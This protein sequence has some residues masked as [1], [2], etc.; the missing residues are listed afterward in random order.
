MK[1]LVFYFI[2]LSAILQSNRLIA[3]SCI[4]YSRSIH[5]RQNMSLINTTGNQ[6]LDNYCRGE[7]SQVCWMLQI[8][9]RLYYYDDGNAPNAFFDPATNNI[10]L[11]K[12]IILMVC[13]NYGYGNAE[14]GFSYGAV[15]PFLIAHEAG[16]AKASQ[17]GWSFRT[18][19]TVKKDEL[20]ADFCAGMYS[21]LQ[22]TLINSAS[23]TRFYGAFNV[24]PI[25]D[26]FGKAG[27]LEFNKPQHHGTPDE[28]RHAV[29][30]GYNFMSDYIFNYQ[31]Y[32]RTTA[33]PAVSD[34]ELYEAASKM[35]SSV[36]D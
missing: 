4:S 20:F 5:G 13:N 2:L 9:P 16:H 23:N 32:Y 21:C 12:N 8:S 34:A 35:L 3:Q 11:G 7:F 25:V 6:Y 30:K 17:L 18:G 26:F 14:P 29:L 10:A 1:R 22:R 28:R 27:D 31:R 36:Y 19:S 24:D 33:I 15:L